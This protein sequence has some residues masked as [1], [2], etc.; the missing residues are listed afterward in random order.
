MLNWVLVSRARN[1]SPSGRG[2]GKHGLCPGNHRKGSASPPKQVSRLADAIILTYQ[3]S[4][5]TSSCL[6]SA[7][8]AAFPECTSDA[9][10]PPFEVLCPPPS[11]WSWDKGQVHNT[12]SFTR[13]HLTYSHL[14]PAP[15]SWPS[16]LSSL[17]LWTLL[18]LSLSSISSRGRSLALLS[19]ASAP[20][21]PF[22]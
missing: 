7:A 15:H 3:L 8:R 21:P 12:V 19:L 5:C 2:G 11:P 10:T 1:L 14:L 4:P 6:P 22:L 16:S 13:S 20:F 18:P 9:V 17:H